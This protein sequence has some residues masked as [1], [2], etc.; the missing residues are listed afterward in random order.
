[1]FRIIKLLASANRPPIPLNDRSLTIHFP[2]SYSQLLDS[3]PSRSLRT[4]SRAFVSTID[5]TS[6]SGSEGE[7]KLL[8][9]LH[10]RFPKAKTIEVTD[11]SG[12]CGSMYT[13]IVESVEF[14]GTRT[15]RQHQLV[16]EVLKEEIKHNMHGLRI[17]TA[18]PEDS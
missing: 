14:K 2:H 5:D 18:V 4:S 11:I 13:V 8:R 9:L 12:G 10:A 6:K 17:Y 7:L 16:N 3:F 1:M 15:V